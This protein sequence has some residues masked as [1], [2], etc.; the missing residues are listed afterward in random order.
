[1]REHVVC[2]PYCGESA[3]AILSVFFYKV[4]RGD[5][6]TLEVEV[7]R[8]LGDACPFRKDLALDIVDNGRLDRN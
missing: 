6:I 5:L 4:D 2:V 7:R 3:T 8:I 1:M